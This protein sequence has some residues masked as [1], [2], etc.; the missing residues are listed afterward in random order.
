M[1]GGTAI[2]TSDVQHRNI[3]RGGPGDDELIGSLPTAKQS[4]NELY[5]GPGSDILNALGSPSPK[6]SGGAGN[7]DLLA[8]DGIINGD[9]GKDWLVLEGS[10]GEWSNGYTIPV[11]VEVD[12]GAGYRRC[13]TSSG[14][15]FAEATLK[16]IESIRGSADADI[17]RGSIAANIIKGNGGDDVI[18]G[19]HG[20]DRLVG[21]PGAVARSRPPRPSCSR[22][23]A[24][25]SRPS[26]QEGPVIARF[27]TSFR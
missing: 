15:R 23:D 16:N 5:G 25:G 19:R 11:P 21:G 8:F 3:L 13:T 18:E 2:D 6:L 27:W 4:F 20:D 12:L 10:R 7:N 9:D 24:N 26:V 1:G 22:A 17:L 14:I